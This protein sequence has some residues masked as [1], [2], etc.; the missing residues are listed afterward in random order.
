MC[1]YMYNTRT[2]I[3]IPLFLN[4]NKYSVRKIVNTIVLTNLMLTS[5]LLPTK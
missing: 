4:T 5:L 3:K 2:L 1:Y